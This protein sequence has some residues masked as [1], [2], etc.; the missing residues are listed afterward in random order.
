[1]FAGIRRHTSGTVERRT[2][3]GIRRR[4]VE[5]LTGR[6]RDAAHGRH[7]L[8]DRLAARRTACRNRR[9][10]GGRILARVANGRKRLAKR[11]AHFR[12][13]R[14]RDGRRTACK[15]VFGAFPAMVANPA[16]QPGRNQGANG[17]TVA[18]IADRPEAGRG[19]RS[20]GGAGL[21]DAFRRLE[22]GLQ[23]RGA[24]GRARIRP[25]RADATAGVYA[26]F[27]AMV[28][29]GRRN[30]GANGRTADGLP[31]VAAFRCSP[32]SGG[33]TRA[34][35]PGR[36][37]RNPAAQP[38]RRN[39]GAA[40]PG[41]RNQGGRNQGGATRAGATRARLAID[42]KRTARTVAGIR[43]HTSGTVERLRGAR[44][45]ESG[46]TLPARSNGC[47]AH[48]R[49]NPAAQPG[50]RTACRWWRRGRIADRPEAG[51]GATRARRVRLWRA[52]KVLPAT[53]ESKRRG[54][55]CP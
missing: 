54:N 41:R 3:A 37:R 32:E 22:T 31:M 46:G 48:G 39:Q 18:G 19:A 40:Q 14:T 20:N 8:P 29:D 11:T 5:P 28:A 52:A 43:R 51:R 25:A 53:A 34:A 12:R 1:M 27:P 38:G 33:A 50:R 30:Q 55:V 6:K 49:R 7:G 26:A 16:A 35:Q 2:V 24:A 23:G 9:G 36:V 15:G 45:P 17:R 44:L 42:R 4:T 21:A 10:T 13:A 47:A